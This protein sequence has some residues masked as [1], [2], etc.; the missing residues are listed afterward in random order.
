MRCS[1]PSKVSI[2]HARTVICTIGIRTI[3]G[4]RRP[5]SKRGS[6]I[7]FAA[8]SLFE[9][10]EYFFRHHLGVRF[11]PVFLE[12]LLPVLG[13]RASIIV[14]ETRISV[15]QLSGPAVG[16]LNVAQTFDECIS[17]VGIFHRRA[18]CEAI[19]GAHRRYES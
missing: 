11:L 2:K 10:V 19:R 1:T 12:I 7:D 6:S 14:N 16:V 5:R 9:K 17:A 4:L 15:R 3:R 8:R 18:S 13:P